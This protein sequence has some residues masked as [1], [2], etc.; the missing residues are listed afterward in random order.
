MSEDVL[1]ASQEEFVRITRAKDILIDI[2][3]REAYDKYGMFGVNMFEKGRSNAEIRS[4]Q[5]GKDYRNETKI[6]DL[7]QYY[8]KRE[9]IMELDKLV[10]SYGHIELEFDATNTPVE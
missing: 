6:G 10:S 4:W 7:L 9:A 1:N 5:I 2:H 3:I 8:M